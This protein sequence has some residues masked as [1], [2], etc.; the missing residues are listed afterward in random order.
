M[1]ATRS[2]IIDAYCQ[3]TPKSAQ[4][5]EQ[6]AQIFPGGVTHDGRFLQPYPIYVERAAGS[7]KWDVDDHEYVD[8]SGGHGALLLGHNHPQ[9]IQAAAA[10]LAKGTHY[11]SCHELEVRWGQLVQRLVPCAER[12]RFTGSGTEATLLALR[13]SRAFTG[14]SKIMRFAGHF[15]GWHDHAAFGVYNHYDGTPTPGVLDEIAQQVVLAPA[16]DI[17]ATRTILDSQNDVAGIIIEPTGA[18]WGQVPL[19]PEFLSFLREET[20]ARGIV[21]TFDE[22]IS[23]FRVSPGGAQAHYGITPDLTTLAK[24]VAGGMPGGAIVGRKSIMDALDFAA[25][26]ASGKEK[27]P[28]Q[29]TFNANP[30]C[31]AAGIATLEIVSGTDACERASDYAAR[32]REELNRVLHDEKVPWAVYG[33]FSGFHIFTN[34]D[35][36]EITPA[37]IAAGKYDYRVLKKANRDLV[38]KLR[39]GMLIHGVEIFAWPGGPT[40]SVHTEDDLQRTAQA[41]RKTLRMLREE[42]AI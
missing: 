40:S 29:G 30:V 9:V 19:L 37:D 21:L 13:L 31:A 22:V 32:L 42:G 20:A 8:Y 25:T 17:A 14:K 15:H 10:Q 27:I 18:S 34:P 33:T 23:G 35:R 11:G 39:L 26:Q 4:L 2:A 41:F 1:H 36:L 5:A 7:R 3:R 16:G 12:I 6:A 38:T 24:I 28:H